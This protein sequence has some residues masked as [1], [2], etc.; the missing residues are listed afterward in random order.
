MPFCD[1]CSCEDCRSGVIRHLDADGKLVR[2]VRGKLTH[3]PTVDG[4]W[5][6]D[7]CWRYTVCV[8]AKRI[9]TGNARAGGPCEELVDGR[10]VPI[11]CSHRPILAGSF[12]TSATGGSTT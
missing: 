7:V 9:E 12:T 2:E 4:R 3:A 1:F 10:Y 8:S 6:C 11:Q 5:I